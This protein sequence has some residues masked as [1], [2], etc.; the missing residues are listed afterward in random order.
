METPTCEARK[1]NGDMCRRPLDDEGN[2]WWWRDHAD[3]QEP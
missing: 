3:D 2:C 1:K